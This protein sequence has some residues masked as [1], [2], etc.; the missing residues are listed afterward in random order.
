VGTWQRGYWQA[1][2]LLLAAHFAGWAGALPLAIVLSV[3][4]V[5]HAVVLRRS[6]VAF[7]VQVRLAY[8]GLL[9]LGNLAPLWPLLAALFIGVNVRLV[10]DYCPLARLLVLLPWNRRVPLS[11]PLLRWLLLSL[12]ESGSILSRLAEQP[13]HVSSMKPD[14]EVPRHRVLGRRAAPHRCGGLIR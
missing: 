1:S 2:A 5:N 14:S 13:F 12:P 7:D 4:Q 9:T 10:T 11:W 8:L 6:L 3:L